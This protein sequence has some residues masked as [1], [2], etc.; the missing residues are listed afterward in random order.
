MSTF[1]TDEFV[2]VDDDAPQGESGG[3]APFSYVGMIIT[4]TVNDTEAKVQ[5][6]FGA[7]THWLQHSGYILRGA[8]ADVTT[9]NNVKDGGSD[10]AFLRSHTHTFTGTA[11]NTG[12]VSANHQHTY[13]R[14][15][16]AVGESWGA[17]GRKYTDSYGSTWSGTIS[18]NHTHSVTA[19]GTNATVGDGADG[20]GKNLPNYKNVYIWERV[21]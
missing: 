10:D 13:D 3:G 2:V 4:D 17:Q 21:S 1:N 5:A 12:T 18:A 19:K 6:I 20:T 16:A 15:A 7:N 8:A 9:N 11:V 14:Y